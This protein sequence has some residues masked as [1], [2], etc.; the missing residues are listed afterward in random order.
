MHGT[1]YTPA[2][3]QGGGKGHGGQWGQNPPQRNM[4]NDGNKKREKGK[5]NRKDGKG[6]GRHG[7]GGGYNN[8]H[9]RGGKG[10]RKG[11]GGD[12]GGGGH[13][14]GGGGGGGM[15]FP[16]P[17]GDEFGRDTVYSSMADVVGKV[18]ARVSCF[19]PGAEGHGHEGHEGHERHGHE[20]HGHAG[21]A[22]SACDNTTFTATTIG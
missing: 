4:H 12:H 16:G 15:N 10:N 9:E 21:R 18:W 3:Q 2:Y 11:G 20:G 17:P 13:Y 22:H 14:G 6:K 19:P 5:K 7:G 8:D 1:G